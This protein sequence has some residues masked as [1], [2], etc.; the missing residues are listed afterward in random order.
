MLSDDARGRLD[1]PTADPIARFATWL[2]AARAVGTDRLPEPTAFLLATAT[3]DAVPSVRAM[4]L[5][6][7]D[8][9]G[10]VF[11]TNYTSRKAG[12]LLANPRAAM[13]FH[14]QPLERQVRVEGDVAPVSDAEA[15]AYF[16]SR[17][18]LS[19]LGA[20]ASLQSQPMPDPDALDRRFA[21]FEAKFAGGDVPRP[22]HWSGFRVTPRAI[23][24]WLAKPGR[25]HVRHRYTPSGEG[26][27]IDTLFP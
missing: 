5:K 6:A 13:V 26:W 20:W 17:P 27:K 24:F 14:W 22:P 10:F 25:L 23:E 2:D 3:R 4:L 16:A 21:E 9:A 12:E 1:E 7:V 11:Y 8:D 18:R 19:Q 15:D